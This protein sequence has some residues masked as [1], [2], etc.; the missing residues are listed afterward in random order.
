LAT[1]LSVF[2]LIS[3]ASLFQLPTLLGFTLQSF[4]PFQGS[5]DLFRS[6]FP[7]VQ[8]LKKPF[9]LLPLLQWLDPPKKAVPYFGSPK[10]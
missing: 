5:N 3:S 7:L 9:G 6:F 4:S 2:D 10:D 1:L 8:F